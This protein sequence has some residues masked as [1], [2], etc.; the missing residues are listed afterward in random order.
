MTS[1][2]SVLYVLQQM[3]HSYCTNVLSA[4]KLELTYVPVLSINISNDNNTAHHTMM[5]T[6]FPL[7]A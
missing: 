3:S 6:R 1:L 2:A 5:M 7:T 4:A